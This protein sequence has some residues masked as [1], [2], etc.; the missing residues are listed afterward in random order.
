MRVAALVIALCSTLALAGCAAG[1]VEATEPAPATSTAAPP[2]TDPLAM[3]SAGERSF[4]RS[5]TS[6]GFSNSGGNAGIV[7]LARTICADLLSGTRPAE[8]Q[9]L[10]VTPS[11]LTAQ[12]AATV[13]ELA[14]TTTCPQHPLPPEGPQMTVSQE[15]ALDKAESYLS[16][17]AFSRSG[18]IEQLEFEGF[19]TDDATFA[20][21]TVAVDWMQ[22]AALKAKSYM[23][24]T[25][26]SRSGLINQLEFEGFTA[27]QAKHGADS[28]GL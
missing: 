21:D 9:T 13:Y 7:Q 1:P 12:E 18:L 3:Y 8:T 19:S 26:F 20:V 16:L 6:A 5:Y 2:T 28:V 27:A 25:S 10:L 23:D 22:Q 14:R 11:G 17:T 24:L 4:I 15:N